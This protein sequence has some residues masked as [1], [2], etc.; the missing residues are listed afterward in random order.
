MYTSDAP[1]ISTGP[2]T[3]L[4]HHFQDPLPDSLTP[5]GALRTPPGLGDSVNGNHKNKNNGLKGHVISDNSNFLS[6]PDSPFSGGAL[7]A[8]QEPCDSNPSFHLGSVPIT[9]S[10]FNIPGPYSN[11][12]DCISYESTPNLF[13]NSLPRVP[14]PLTPEGAHKAPLGLADSGTDS[15]YHKGEKIPLFISIKAVL[16][17][18]PPPLGP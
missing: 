2:D 6:P 5:G 18:L 10:D 17:T 7:K 4:F 3:H 15:H 12:Y 16:G 1:I 8:P 9:P 11:N 14:D 13:Q